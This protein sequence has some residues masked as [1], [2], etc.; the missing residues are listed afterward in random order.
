[1]SAPASEALGPAPASP[2]AGLRAVGRLVRHVAA[3]PMGL[4][5]LCL[6][7]LLVFTG[8]FAEW[9]SPYD[10]K[11]IAVPDRFQG[12][13]WAHWVG[14]DHLGRDMLSRVIEGTQIALFVGVTAIVTSMLGGLALGLLAGYG[15]RWLDHLLV[16][17]FD[18]IYSFPTVMLALALVTLLGPDLT[19][20]MLVVVVGTMPAYAR[21][22]RTSTLSIKNADFVLAERSLGARTPRVLLR[23]ILPNVVGP[24]FIIG[25]MDIP[26]AITLEAGLSFL[27]LGVRPPTPSWGSI[28]NDGYSW[29]RET[30]WIVI[31]GG[32]PL[33]I[34]TLGFTFLGEALRDTLDPKLR[35]QLRNA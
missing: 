15:P 22:V 2:S 11:K 28:L 32:V 18:A 13:S 33:I 12:P 6:V 4:L 7:L 23:H 24:L 9:L 5:G 3:D 21:L 1:V 16:L 35:R 25:S 8:V 34:S 10:P 14:T 26:V 19:T 27:G 29:I 20:V 30:P 31:G 17:L